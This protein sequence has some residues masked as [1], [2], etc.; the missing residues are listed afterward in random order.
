VRSTYLHLIERADWVASRE[1]WQVK[2]RGRATP[3]VLDMEARGDAG[4]ETGF[5]VW[6][7]VMVERW[8]ADVVGATHKFQDEGA[9]VED[10]K[11]R[12]SV[13]PWRRLPLLAT[14]SHGRARYV[15][16]RRLGR[17]GG[18]EHGAVPLRKDAVDLKPG[19][20]NHG[21]IALDFG[22]SNS[23]VLFGVQGSSEE[24]F[25][26]QGVEERKVR[27]A[28][29]I[30][31]AGAR[32]P[33]SL[34]NSLDV[35]TAWYEVPS[36]GPLL[37]TL[38]LKKTN[39]TTGD[40]QWSVLPRDPAL[41]R[42]VV[43]EP[44]TTLL[45]NLK[46][47]E[48]R[49]SD[50]TAL[51]VY[52][53]RILMPAIFDLRKN[54][55]GTVSVALSFPLA[56]DDTRLARLTNAV[57]DTLERLAARTG[58]TV[59]TVRRYSESHAGVRAIHAAI[60]EYCLTLDMGGGTTDLAV[61][62]GNHEVLAA[63]SLQIG[64]RR[65][66]SM[67]APRRPGLQDALLQALGAQ[68]GTRVPVD[69][70]TL[71]ETLLQSGG[72]NKVVAAISP[73]PSVLRRQA[74]AALVAAVVLAARRLLAYSIPRGNGTA[75]VNAYLLGQGWGLLSPGLT[76]GITE[77]SLARVLEAS[78]DGRFALR[79]HFAGNGAV[80]RKT[81]VVHGA[82]Q[83]L[84]A[85]ARD[86]GVTPVSFVGVDLALSGGGVVSADTRLSSVH[87]LNIAAGD[88]GFR[89]IV[90]ELVALM[91]QLS[92]NPIGDPK[93][94][95]AGSDPTSHGVTGEDALVHGGCHELLGVITPGG[96][97]KWSPLFRFLSKP[98]ADFWMTVVQT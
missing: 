51:E 60:P 66:L 48:L 42:N 55:A 72:V 83:L 25:V 67:I 4:D 7:P 65:L 33:S 92:A 28:C 34:C 5:A 18:E 68:P 39:P 73:D 12:M 27:E 49:Q 54:G 63:D 90:H 52:L 58:I 97:L 14:S 11:G 91:S 95:L 62:K 3:D 22:T 38:L 17:L 64:A 79:T 98:W 96:G 19:A 88:P 94:L 87:D 75:H 47:H 46:W 24:G 85:D 89:A 6:P 8:Q 35:F 2:L 81:R 10:V 43:Q 32:F 77:D 44:N 45:A 29:E 53:E 57:T 13:G 40:S 16:L 21:L 56:F 41:I 80:E 20:P 9:L 71:M 31:H 70:A 37:G 15:V 74:V 82:M 1:R 61:M 26:K 76:P 86:S 93:R 30:S 23:V 36:P 59:T 50:Q 78:G 69:E 84:R